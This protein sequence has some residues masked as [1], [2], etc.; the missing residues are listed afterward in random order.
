V[1]FVNGND[2]VLSHPASAAKWVGVLRAPTTGRYR[3]VTRGCGS[4]GDVWIDGQKV[5]QNGAFGEVHLERGSHEIEVRFPR[6]INFPMA[7]SLLWIRP[8]SSV[9]EVVSMEY[10]G[11]TDIR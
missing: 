2:F 5:S 11:D 1:N 7:L 4:I 9:Q 10:F 3:F 6:P 8:G